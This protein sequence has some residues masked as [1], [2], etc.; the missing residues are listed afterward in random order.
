M[1]VHIAN[2]LLIFHSNHRKTPKDW[3]IAETFH[4]VCFFLYYYLHVHCH[5]IKDIQYRFLKKSKKKTI[6]E[7]HN[8][9]LFFFLNISGWLL[10]DTNRLWRSPATVPCRWKGLPQ[11]VTLHKVVNIVDIHIAFT[12]YQHFFLSFILKSLNQTD[13]AYGLPVYYWNKREDEN[14]VKIRPVFEPLMCCR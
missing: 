9:S 11:G 12:I 5:S 3:I 4:C 1:W 13:A 10:L 2:S 8:K 14:Q 6:K 7:A